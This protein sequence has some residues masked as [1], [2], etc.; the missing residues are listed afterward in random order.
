ML[1]DASGWHLE[2][3]L[4]PRC[5]VPAAFSWPP[6]PVPGRAEFIARLD[7]WLTIHPELLGRPIPTNQTNL[8]GPP[9]VIG[10]VPV[11]VGPAENNPWF[12]S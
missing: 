10:A 12:L 4:A 7:N 1:L 5:P 2:P 8:F 3:E 9:D 6:P 11:V